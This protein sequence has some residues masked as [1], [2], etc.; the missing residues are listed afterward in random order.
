LAD[1]NYSVEI[2]V[3]LNTD[4]AEQDLVDFK[5]ELT[6]LLSGGGDLKFAIGG[7]GSGEDINQRIIDSLKRG[8]KKG[9]E[10]VAKEIA[11][12]L[13]NI[14]AEVIDLV[15]DNEGSVKR[16]LNELARRY[17]K[18]LGIDFV[19]NIAEAL[20]EPDFAVPLEG[21]SPRRRQQ[22]TQDFMT[23]GQ[24]VIYSPAAFISAFE[25][26]AA[27]FP[28]ARFG[29]GAQRGLEL[30]LTRGALNQPVFQSAI[31]E[32]TDEMLSSFKNLI[33]NALGMENASEVGEYLRNRAQVVL[34][35]IFERGFRAREASFASSRI[36]EGEYDAENL[37]RYAD[38]SARRAI[39][40]AEEEFGLALGTLARHIHTAGSQFKDLETPYK[41]TQINNL[42]AKL[43]DQQPQSASAE[44]E[45][46]ALKKL[47]M[48]I[49]PNSAEAGLQLI[50]KEARDAFNEGLVQAGRLVSDPNQ[51]RVNVFGDYEDIVGTLMSTPTNAPDIM[52]QVFLNPAILAAGK[53]GVKNFFEGLSKLVVTSGEGAGGPQQ[54]LQEL[55]A[56]GRKLTAGF[57]TE[58]VDK[59][60][61]VLTEA[62]VVIKNDLGKLYSVFDLLQAPPS[63]EEEIL[64]RTQVGARSR[65]ELQKRAQQLGYGE[66]L[67]SAEGLQNLKDYYPKL[68][69]LI[70][71]LNQIAEAGI[72][73]TGAN[74]Q[75]ADFNRIAKAIQ[76][77]NEAISGN[78]LDLEP[79]QAPRGPYSKATLQK[80]PS[81][82]PLGLP[83]TGSVQDVQRMMK[84][85]TGANAQGIRALAEGSNKVGDLL[86][87]VAD[88]LDDATRNLIEF[89]KKNFNISGMP[90]H[91]ARAD[92]AAAA[93]IYDAIE[94]FSG[95]GRPPS[96]GL[97]ARRVSGIPEEGYEPFLNQLKGMNS[98]LSDMAEKEKEIFLTRLQGFTTTKEQLAIYHKIEDVQ[99]EITK[100]EAK[101]PSEVV[102]TGKPDDPK[103]GKATG[104]LRGDAAARREVQALQ[105]L[106][107]S[108]QEAGE[109]N[110]RRFAAAIKFQMREDD[111]AGKNYQHA[112]QRIDSSLQVEKADRAQRDGIIAGIKEQV[113]AEK[114]LESQ[115]KSLMNTWVTGR[116]ALYDVGNAYE[117][118][119]RQLALA[120][121]RIFEVTNAYRSYETAF[122]SV[123]RTIPTL[124]ASVGGAAD[125][126]RSL[127]DAFIG[128][129]EE[130]PLS[131]E[132]LSQIATLGAQ[133]GV[134][135]SGIVEFTKTV[136]QFAA[137]TNISAETVAQK[138]GRIAE[139]ADVD[140]SQMN[141]LGSAV[142]F[143]GI[144]A[145]ATEAEI[146][147]LA[148]SIAAVS[149]Q[150]GL[151]PAEIIGV[152]TA[153]ASI[154]IQAEQA[155]GVF[156][157]VFA[158]IDRAVS[159]GG[160]ELGAF[161]EIAGMSAD[162][163]SSAWGEEGASYDV[164]RAILGGL[165]A[166]EDLTKAFDSL[167]IV[168]TREI[169]TLTRLAKNLNVV[170]QAVS[171]SN[172]SFETGA[173]LGSAFERTVDNLDSKIQVLKNN[174][175][176]LTEELSG[177]TSG[178]LIV[179]IDI[180]N[181]L[182]STFKE[183]AKNP[184]YQFAASFGLGL[185]GIAAAA[186][187]T[188]AGLTK[189]VAQMYAFRV[190]AIN[191]ANDPTAI[192][193]F[194]SMFRQITGWGS[195]LIE[196]RK[197]L[198]SI[199]PATKGII[200]PVTLSLFGNFEK[201]QRKLLENNILLLDSEKLGLETARQRADSIN[202]LLK[203]R[204]AEIAS[205]VQ[206]TAMTEAEKAASLRKITSDKI[207]VTTTGEIIRG[208]ITETEA[209][210][211]NLIA[212][213]AESQ[214]AV[215]AQRGVQ[216]AGR[217]GAASI[218]LGLATGLGAVL[219]VA[220]L[221]GTAIGYIAQEIEKTKINILES[222]GGVASL[223]DAIKQDTQAFQALTPE[224]QNAT[225]KFITFERQVNVSTT[226]VDENARAIAAATGTGQDFV[227]ANQKVT[228]SVETQTFAIG[229]NTR[230]WFANA[231]MQDEN[232][233]KLLKS[234]PN[235]FND[236]KQFGLDFGQILN[237]VMSNPDMNINT[238]LDEQLSET[239]GKIRGRLDQVREEMQ[240]LRPT[241][242]G[243]LNTEQQKRYDLLVQENTKLVDQV[244]LLDRAEEAIRSIANA[245]KAGATG[246][247]LYNYINDALGVM[248]ELGDETDETTD[249]TNNLAQA[250]RTV[251]DYANDLSGIFS[252]VIELEFGKEMSDDAITRGWREITK[253]A[254]SA[255]DAIE[256]ANR[257]IKDLTADK[258]ILEYQLSVAERYGD[259]LR[260]AKI[261]AE[262]AKVNNQITDS[263]KDL[264]DA[265]DKASMGL[266]GNTDA[267][268]ENRA[269]VL[270][271]V[272]EYQQR[273]EM[274]AKLGRTPK[275]LA[276]DIDVLKKRFRQQAIAA[277]FAAEEID[278]YTALFDQFG[279]AVDKTPYDV[280]IKVNLGISAA[281][282]ALNEFL[283]KNRETTVD[284]KANTDPAK[285]KIASITEMQWKF[286]NIVADRIDTSKAEAYLQQ[287]LNRG[288]T[289]SMAL[290]FD[291]AQI[292]RAQAS[293]IYKVYTALAAVRSPLAESYREQYLILNRIANGM[294][295]GG[296]VSGRGTG[297]SDSIP[298]MLSNGEFVVQAR[299]V[300]TYGVDFMNA[301]NQQ[302]VPVM[303]SSAGGSRTSLGGSTIAQLSPEDRA[304][305]RA[306]VNRP[307][308]LYAD[309]T[310]IAQSANAGNQV[311]SQ[312][313]SK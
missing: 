103:I 97:D 115:N 112:R 271:M 20:G 21:M 164:L 309:N 190:A 128:M 18:M 172:T 182:L 39:A 187:F 228:D 5:K 83:D 107:I 113:A 51:I 208:K 7:Y 233:Q 212:I 56:S 303:S 96:D 8:N 209:R 84:E 264:A 70:D 9:N 30:G 231:I 50:G 180:A 244:N 61:S 167:N 204:Q 32:L 49:T 12:G 34:D 77:V 223:R 213:N 177:T 116:Y 154:G 252:R 308:T 138:F 120:A 293:A 41:I 104:E 47:I 22:A 287:W 75:G 94:P 52:E 249:A 207:Y 299:A 191:T 201:S 134:S 99:Q 131:F 298:A 66:P 266:T 73:L 79:L 250:L 166:T 251:L 224:Q 24:Q 45:I 132:Q 305:L 226:A 114:K 111:F 194:A 127:K 153:L 311:L 27:Q 306:V 280:D 169:N 38:A 225:D 54:G 81:A 296:F 88:R 222:G 151:L 64:G 109:A 219:S 203:F 146:L 150:A 278:E 307:V 268:L 269:A 247:E 124:A 16:E 57:D 4:K 40:E 255:R 265:Q 142:A 67:G 87:G 101:R 136:A 260:A 174:F 171:D 183:L 181:N 85:A 14:E 68:K 258:S 6:K 156:T 286:K 121:R 129:S 143:A 165:G 147:T 259:E 188:I 89:N 192:S 267:A 176:A 149:N 179:V 173:F 239:G 145:V 71:I 122:T 230:A 108:Y 80:Y 313:G 90:A 28:E 141:N 196:I 11:D 130:M 273:I 86:K 198:Q 37:V 276:G 272:G 62:S 211:R 48:D 241:G 234:Y 242:Y 105:G 126:M 220:T 195:G 292:V 262:L 302:R 44:Q 175:M 159:K 119:S 301:L 261:R 246:A 289:L 58:F 43:K 158:D 2:N 78:R 31:P 238:Y 46:N 257:E 92:A 13:G 248:Q 23:S 148:E 210:R 205:I 25:K 140:Y 19:E 294:A 100:I 123:E 95:Q 197:D 26:I 256:D 72:P 42:I 229:Q 277:G 117:S 263:E 312:R 218:F 155:R 139:L 29:S 217:A 295:T 33:H 59:L 82:F 135:A 284:V 65:A 281:E 93:I 237:D 178:A 168:E 106:I 221:I 304:L 235:F 36:T 102:K 279:I 98:V 63:S 160:K 245:M 163:F 288:R 17:A 282:Q 3:G 200:T 152:S 270:G 137:I 206:N 227:D 186:T 110:E 74:L 199:S 291:S 240:A 189:L 300:K 283:A 35:E 253:S 310:K 243:R 76:N 236:I 232:I 55:I 15:K 133:M 290:T 91:T 215:T 161:A 254:Q 157:R 202:Q 185:T 118:V 10:R 214:A 216:S 285:E 1:K 53:D 275:Q 144:N 184:F 274:L 125:E 170:D 60:S 193:G 162:E 69:A 297:T